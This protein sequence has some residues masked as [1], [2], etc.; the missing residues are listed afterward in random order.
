MSKIKNEII[1]NSLES[2]LIISDYFTKKSKNVKKLKF[3]NNLLK[4]KAGS[5]KECNARN[6]VYFP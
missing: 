4:A 6:I 1:E 2:K 3:L 5:L